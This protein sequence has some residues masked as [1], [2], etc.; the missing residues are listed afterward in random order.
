MG[1]ISSLEF[2]PSDYKIKYVDSVVKQQ[3]KIHKSRSVQ[4]GHKSV[5]LLFGKGIVETISCPDDD[6]TIGW[7]L[8]VATR[9]YE[10][11][12]EKGQFKEKAKQLV[13]GLKTVESIP[14][15]DYYLTHL[16]NSLEPIKD[17]TLLAVHYAKLSEE[18][19]V[20]PGKT[21]V[22]KNSFQYLKVIGCGGY[23][24]VVLARK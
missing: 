6:M 20:T 21:E 18:D 17:N 15:I 13:V 5:K 9:L 14:A 24:N 4:I 12:Y 23:S 19:K 16:E 22:N 10:S 3:M 2:V 8:S 7:L 1:V 11:L